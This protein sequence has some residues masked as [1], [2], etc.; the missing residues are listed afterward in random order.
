MKKSILPSR[1]AE[2]LIT[3]KCNLNCS[4]CFE[5]HKN[6]CSLDFKD[7]RKHLGDGVLPFEQ[8]Y[9]FGG[10]P[11]LNMKFIEDAIEWIARN[12]KWDE[13]YKRRLTHSI[14]SNLIT[15]GVALE[16]LIPVLK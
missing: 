3:Q 10:E 9:I 7:F 1:T 5:K 2:I 4:Y 14:C 11:T 13:D 16:D 12:P 15:N 6:G 8:F